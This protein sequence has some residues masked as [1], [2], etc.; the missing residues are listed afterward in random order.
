M[1]IVFVLV[2]MGVFALLLLFVQLCEAGIIT[3]EDVTDES[4]R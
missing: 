4:R 2:V 3:R 1:D